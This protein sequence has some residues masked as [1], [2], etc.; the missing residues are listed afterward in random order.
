MYKFEKLDLS[1]VGIQEVSDL[2]NIVF[3]NTNVN[4][5][6]YLDWEYNHNPEGNAI[7]F[8]AYLDNCLAAHYVTQPIKASING[9]ETRGLLSLN[10]ATHPDHRGKKLFTILAEM[11][12]EYA[13]KEGYSFVIGVANQNSIRGFVKHLGFDLIKPLDVKIGLGI[14]EEFQNYTYSF[15]R[16]WDRK[17]INWR[18]SNPIK[19]YRVKKKN[20]STYILAQTGKWGINAIIGVFDN[21]QSEE[22]NFVNK[23][24]TSNVYIWMGVNDRITWKK[25]AYI[26]FP[27]RL[28]PSPLNLIFKDL[29]NSGLVLNSETIKFQ[30]I[31]F[32]AF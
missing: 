3:P 19:K 14:H 10:T 1:M 2:L 18:L 16:V 27:N 5:V 7:G 13:A 30:C 21:I 31:D 4:S 32:D 23:G 24:L 29:T 28:K 25:S 26:S 17:S 11:T 12:Y 15:F 9:V 8:N 6:E 20:E 22:I